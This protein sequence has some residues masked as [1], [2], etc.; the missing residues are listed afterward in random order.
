MKTICFLPWGYPSMERSAEIAACYLEAGCDAIEIGIPPR[1]AYLDN[2]YLR[3]VMR[4]AYEQCPDPL[5]YLEDIRAFA[6]AHPETELLLLL[7]DETIRA[8]GAQRL[9][10]F[11]REL[12]IDK[13][14]SGDLKDPA[15][16]DELRRGG[17]FKSSGTGWSMPEEAVQNCLGDGGFVYLRAALTPGET[18]RPGCETLA[19]CV[20]HLR[21]A[22]VTRPI[23]CGMGIH[24][25]ADA[26]AAREAGTDGC[27]VGSS[28]VKLVDQPRELIETI[29]SYCAAAK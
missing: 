12:R 11:C 16:L 20:R 27:F 10:A 19:G 15:L 8:I 6:K 9:T 1:D 21:E 13:L 7:Y 22:G 24:A 5:V 3:G 2:E 29:R 26:A 4:R 14:V 28:I 23:Y 18:P 17:L 25:P